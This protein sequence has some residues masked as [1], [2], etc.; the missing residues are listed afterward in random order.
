M[1]AS[2]LGVDN[3]GNGIGG[4]K[5]W[6]IRDECPYRRSTPT[7][8]AR[9]WNIHLNDALAT[10]DCFIHAL[11]LGNSSGLNACTNCW[12]VKHSVWQ[13]CI[14]KK[15]VRIWVLNQRPK[16]SN[17]LRNVR[18]EKFYRCNI[19]RNVRNVNFNRFNQ[20][21]EMNISTDA[22]VLETLEKCII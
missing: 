13:C 3:E 6:E 2:H 14:A 21:F 16:Q 9:C 20:F 12:M 7:N 11:H 8:Y 19:L 4:N 22:T 15:S 10:P 17:I 18:N 1:I 5:I